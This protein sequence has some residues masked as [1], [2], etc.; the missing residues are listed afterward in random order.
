MKKVSVYKEATKP[1]TE[2]KN[3]LL[4]AEYYTH[5]EEIEERYNEL[6]CEE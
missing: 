1:Y 2:A 5:F 4:Q 6:V 3:L